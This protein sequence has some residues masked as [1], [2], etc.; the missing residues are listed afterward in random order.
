MKTTSEFH[1]SDTVPTHELGRM[2]HSDR[3]SLQQKKQNEWEDLP[4]T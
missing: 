1:S 2:L 3:K 4:E